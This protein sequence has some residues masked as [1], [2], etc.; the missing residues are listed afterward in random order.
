MVRAQVEGG[1]KNGAAVV[2]VDSLMAAKINAVA[3]KINAARELA[4][5]LAE[6]K[7]AAAKPE[8]RHR[9]AQCS[10]RHTDGGLCAFPQAA[11]CFA[12]AVSLIEAAL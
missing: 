7:N 11:A 8:V 10:A 6:E 2:G 5:R 9:V 12:Q 1:Q 3:G 4:R